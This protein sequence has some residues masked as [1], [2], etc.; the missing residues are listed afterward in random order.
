MSPAM[1]TDAQR[2]RLYAA[3]DLVAR[4]LD[5]ATDHPVIE[6]AGSHLTLPVERRFG[7]IPAVQRYADAV[8][9]L[10]WVRHRWPRA[11]CPVMVRERQG[12]SRAHYQWA[13]SVLAVPAPADGGRWALRELVILHELAHH[14]GPVEDPGHGP[15]FAGR[16]LDLV[17]GIIGPEV[18]LLLRVNFSD[19]GVT[20]G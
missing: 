9:A 14:L 4:I 18:A 13:G 12:A 5:R 17:E 7:D 15:A 8:L 16:M 19:T 20:V 10:T 1:E 3:E 2:S 6:V 11:A